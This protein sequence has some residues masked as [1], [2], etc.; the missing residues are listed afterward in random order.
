MDRDR[1]PDLFCFSH[2]RW[3]FVYQRPQH[4]M[5]RF[6]RVCRVFFVEEPVFD[7]ATPRLEITQAQG[8]HV[9]V[10]H[11]PTA[12]SEEQDSRQRSLL[13]E[14]FKDQGIRHPVLWYYTPM[15]LSFT[16]HLLRLAVVYDC[17]DELSAF[18]FAPPNLPKLEEELFGVTDLVFTGG[19]SLYEAKRHRHPAVYLFPSSVDADHFGRAR[20]LSDHPDQT[21]IPHPRIGFFGV[22]DE[23]MDLQLLAQVAAARPDWHIILVGPVVKID[24][25]SLPRGPNLHYMGQRGYDELP[26][27][28]AGWKVTLLPFARNQATRYISPTKVPE[29]LAAGLP[30]VS[31]SI[32]DVVLT[33]G[34]GGLARIADSAPRFINAIDEAM[35][36]DP[37]TRLD[38]AA[39]FL[40]RRSWDRTWATMRFLLADVVSRAQERG[41]ATTRPTGVR[42]PP[43]PAVQRIGRV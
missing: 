10:P 6:G 28:L 19:H 38:Q 9:V 16:R 5:T 8:V 26:A 24:P 35:R 22:I 43:P 23:R 3:N 39:A 1:L 30:V 17:M 20:T 13:D 11:L 7:S 40:A 36:E 33:F 27:F 32:P 12:Q 29:Y 4:L 31:T 18:A 21:A 34:I 42:V 2:L 41:R 25:Q 14:L 37:G 15:A